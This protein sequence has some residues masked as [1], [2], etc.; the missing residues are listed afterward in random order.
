MTVI[1]LVEA[2]LEF[3]GALIAL[4]LSI[5][6]YSTLHSED[7]DRLLWYLLLPDIALLISVAF[8]VIYDGDTSLMGFYIQRFF[9]MINIG[10]STVL[11]AMYCHYIAKICKDT[12]GL[13]VVD[14]IAGAGMI[15]L[16][17]N[18]LTHFYYYFNQMG[19]YVRK[20]GLYTLF[21]VECYMVIFMIVKL[22][23]HNGLKDSQLRLNLFM[24]LFT[25][26]GFVLNTVTQSQG[27]YCDFVTITLITLV[28]TGINRIRNGRYQAQINLANQELEML[29]LEYSRLLEKE[30]K[31]R[32]E[33][34]GQS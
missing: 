23:N 33:R 1:S 34:E 21:F 12:K 29:M 18:P 17:T 6:S 13:R 8:C 19:V 28:I 14:V 9:H 11:L 2:A 32:K 25:V 5:I 24:I 4:I 22:L 30:E 26:V 7:N 3:W 27:I 16:L 31:E 10:A 20:P 15:G